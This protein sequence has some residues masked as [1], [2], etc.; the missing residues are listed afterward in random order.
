[1]FVDV[2][3]KCRSYTLTQK[4]DIYEYFIS[5]D[6]DTGKCVELIYL[7]GDLIAIRGDLK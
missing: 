7:N 2:T 4:G 1:M 5:I 3:K 6:E